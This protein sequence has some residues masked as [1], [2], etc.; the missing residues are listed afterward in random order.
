MNISVRATNGVEVLEFKG[1]MDAHGSAEAQAQL[2]RLIEA[3]KRTIV[4]NFEKLDYV[5]STGIR[6]LLAVAKQLKVVGGE[7]RICS[8]N[9]VVR[10]VL[11]I[12][13]FTMIFKVFGS[14]AEALEG[15]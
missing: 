3:G 12:S 6:V 5:N 8:L 4:A 14:E 1:K 7:L 15:L 9:E 13:G 2:A 11:D 10:E